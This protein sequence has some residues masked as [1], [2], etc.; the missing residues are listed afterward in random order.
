[1][2]GPLGPGD[3]DRLRA[4]PLT[5]AEV[6]ATANPRLPRGYHHLRLRTPVGYGRGQFEAA[7]T[8]LLTWRMHERAGLAPLVADRRVR[9]DGVA[10]LRLGRGRVCLKV[11]VRV[12]AV[13]DEP[14]RQGFAYG[15]LPGH[16]ERGEERFLVEQE[17]DGTVSFTMAAFSRAGRWFTRLGGP[18]ARAGQVLV[19]ERYV[20]A[21]HTLAQ[22]AT[23]PV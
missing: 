12:V 6:G 19:T 9:V 17:P 2:I 11:P 5:Y 23:E 22:A 14:S 3:V 21:L 15:T 8:A 4:E 13:I 1:M 7:A 16:P 10:V 20:E 18:V